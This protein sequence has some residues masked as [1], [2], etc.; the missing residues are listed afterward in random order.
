MSNISR[1]TLLAGA[2]STGAVF[3]LGST[4]WNR[5]LAEPA[6]PGTG[7]YDEL[8]AP[9]ANGLALPPGFTSRIV[10]TTGEPVGANGYVWPT[11]PDGAA[12]F[13]VSG[14]GWIHT[15]NHE[16]IF[17]NGGGVS[18]IEYDATGEVVNAY[19]IL[20][21]T[22][23]NCAGGP[24]P[25][26]TWLSCEEYDLTEATEPALPDFPFGPGVAGQVWECDPTGET[27]GVA[28]PALGKFSH[29]AVAI[30]PSTNVVYLTEDQG[31][32]H[33]YRFTP[34]TA[35]VGGVAD[36]TSGTLE[37]AVLT[38]PDAV[39]AGTSAVTWIEIPD[40]GAVAAPTRKQVPA[41]VFE[42]GEGAWFDSG[43]VYFVTTRDDRVWAYDTVDSTIEVVYD[44]T[45]GGG[46]LD[47]PDNV[48]VHPT[49]GELFVAE[50]DGNLELV[51]ITPP[52]AS[53]TRTSASFMRI[54]G[55][56]GTEVTGPCF[57]PTGTR[58]HFSSQ[59]GAP[60]GGITYEVAGP[61]NT[62]APDPEI[63]EVPMSVAL[64]LTAAVVGAGVYGFNARR[65]RL[66]IATAPGLQQHET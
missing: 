27:P 8:R 30:D 16:T 61:F 38:T 58:M 1:R 42:R 4:F 20:A 12:T 21:D 37:A 18:A 60:D 15:V 5:A 17:T 35:N 39:P 47:E 45:T 28:L 14:G 44:K 33:F 36:L 25:W 63:P 31:D 24:S 53:G 6:T 51:L 23:V 57:D 13:A 54:T 9:D 48:T 19:R 11:A 10:A 66:Q 34:D 65:D 64:P 62:G 7:P 22:N 59:R 56:D 49:S 29:E 52:S 26:G 50:D 40:P 41:S 2:A 3:G 46:E 55:Q 32:S 43:V